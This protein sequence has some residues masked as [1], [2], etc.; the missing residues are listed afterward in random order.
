MI[1]IIMDGIKLKNI[2]YHFKILNI[3]L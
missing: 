3:F 2:V 1:S